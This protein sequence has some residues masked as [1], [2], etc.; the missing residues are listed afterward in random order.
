[1][2]EKPKKMPL[3][4]QHI[5]RLQKLVKVIPTKDL[6]LFTW[7]NECLQVI[8]QI[9]GMLWHQ[10]HADILNKKAEE[11]WQKRSVTRLNAPSRKRG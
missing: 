4:D 2:K 6:Q 9:Y 7:A 1:M 10:R 5:K 11:A 8:S 3:I